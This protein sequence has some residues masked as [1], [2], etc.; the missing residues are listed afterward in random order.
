MYSSR[1]EVDL[2]YRTTYLR[3]FEKKIRQTF[4]GN[5]SSTVSV[6]NA[7]QR[8]RKRSLQFSLGWRQFTNNW[9]SAQMLS[10]FLFIAQV[11]MEGDILANRTDM[12]N[13][14]TSN[15]WLKVCRLQLAECK[16]KCRSIS[17]L[18]ETA[19]AMKFIK[20]WRSCIKSPKFEECFLKRKTFRVCPL[21]KKKSVW[22][23][24][25]SQ[26]V[27]CYKAEKR[28]TLPTINC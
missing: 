28:K 12:K 5:C 6:R 7:L 9:L 16:A 20:N 25:R 21:F 15:C 4:K 11:A 2:H 23:Y 17:N 1:C 18:S 22:R 26:N 24:E 3:N 8:S 10:W 27:L 13:K 19:A 14:R